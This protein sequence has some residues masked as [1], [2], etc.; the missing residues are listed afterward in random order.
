MSRLR[1]DLQK[2]ITRALNS[3]CAENTSSTPDWILAEYLLGCL[4]AF[5][6]ATQQRENWYG[7]DPRPKLAVASGEK[8]P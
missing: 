1:E 6:R 7:R 5:D 4:V 8:T 2:D 3:A